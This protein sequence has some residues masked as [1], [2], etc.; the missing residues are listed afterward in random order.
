ML[1]IATAG[2]ALALA[3]TTF[4]LSWTHSVEHTQ[5]RETWQVRDRQLQ[6]IKAT[7]EGPG[8]GI[9]VPQGARMTPDGWTYRPN[10]P[11]QSTLLLAAS[12]MTPSSW[13]LCADGD[14]HELGK[15]V[16]EEVALWAAPTCGLTPN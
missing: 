7:V 12:G 5:W 4:T 9:D 15:G 1:C 6:L 2:N 3:V 11:P 14:C 8:A 13:L 10:L 16:G